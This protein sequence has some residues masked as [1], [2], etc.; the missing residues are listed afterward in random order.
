MA[1][2]LLTAISGTPFEHGMSLPLASTRSLGAVLTG[3]VPAL[4]LPLRMRV[5]GGLR[6][7][8]EFTDL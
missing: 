5:D 8:L 1:H 7:R 4:A 2:P 6:H 3:N